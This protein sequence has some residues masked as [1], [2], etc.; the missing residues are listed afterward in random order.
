MPETSDELLALFVSLQLLPR[1][2]LL[3]RQDW[4]DVV[5]PL[6][7]SIGRLRPNLAW[8]VLGIG[9]GRSLLGQSRGRQD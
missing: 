8:F 4:F 1:I 9:A 3:W 7:E 2:P 6:F 5:D